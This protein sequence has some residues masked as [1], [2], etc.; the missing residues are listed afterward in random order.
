VGRLQDVSARFAS[1]RGL[2][3]LALL[4]APLIAGLGLAAAR[5]QSP[6]GPTVVD[7]ELT[8]DADRF[9][10]G[11]LRWSAAH[12]GA[13]RAFKLS[14]ATFDMLF[15]PAYA[16]LMAALYT[17]AARGGRRQ[18]MQALQLAPWAAAGFDYVENGLLLWL[19]RGVNHAAGVVAAR[20]PEGAVVLMSTCA[21]LK[22]ALLGLTAAAALLALAGR[23][24]A[25]R[26]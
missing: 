24:T 15:P 5:F 20:F 21:A 18:P 6:G 13:A 3:L 25:L 11:L 22:F 26:T 8:F 14:V 4:N 12:D 23:I 1:P 19:L 7:L 9:R 17:W 10:H 16:A 2:V